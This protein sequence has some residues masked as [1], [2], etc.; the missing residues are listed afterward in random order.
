[1]TK[2][3]PILFNNRHVLPKGRIPLRILPGQPMDTLTHALKNGLEIGVCMVDEKGEP[4]KALIGTSVIIEDFDTNGEDGMLV[5]TVHGVKRVEITQISNNGA[6][7]PVAEYEELPRWPDCSVNEETQPLAE[8]LQMMFDRYPELSSLHSES[9]NEFSNLS[10]LCQRWL[11]LLPL[12]T[13]EKQ[14]LM[15]ANSCNDTCDYLL[16]LMKDPH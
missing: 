14:E 7:V 11:E 4:S 16:S 10:W 1:M 6:G 13:S 9:S 15:S 2:K 3:M 8:R 5:I 12:P